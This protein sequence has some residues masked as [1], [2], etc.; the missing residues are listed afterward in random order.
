MKKESR[1]MG[2]VRKVTDKGYGF[3]H[4]ES[5]GTVFFHGSDLISVDFQKLKVGTIVEF[6]AIEV[7]D[8]FKAKMI[9]V[10]EDVDY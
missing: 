1:R 2:K 7:P 8:G 4:D 5:L 3:I 6:D 10:V 9:L